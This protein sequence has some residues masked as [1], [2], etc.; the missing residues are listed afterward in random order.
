MNLRDLRY[1]VAVA[2]YRHF[3]RAAE[4]CHVSQPTLS[5]QLAKLED[6]LGVKLFERTNRAVTVTPVGS[7][8]AAAARLAVENAERV[9]EIARENKDPL[10]G[11]LRIGV[12]PTLA[13][14][15]MPWLLRPVRTRLPGLR[16]SL[17]EETTAHLTERLL[18]HEIDAAFLATPVA[19]EPALRAIELFDEPFWLAAPPDHPLAKTAHVTRKDIIEAGL[20]MLSD[21]HCLKQQTLEVCRHRSKE[22]ESSVPD[23]RASSLDTLLELVA[24]G[25]GC[26]L[27][28]AL[29]TRGPWARSR[30]M[31]LKRLPIDGAYRRVSLVLRTTF[32]RAAAV[33]ALAALVAEEVPRDLVR[34]V[35]RSARKAAA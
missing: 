4:A 25:L 22:P 8:V 6:Y 12:L 10:A 19:D 18:R 5:T 20:L 28:P 32:P 16:L 13:P 30:R 14:Y 35:T 27:I 24:A 9:L 33:E 1:L 34:I 3:G 2:D 7:R 21:E 26:T 29:A 31:V 15:L 23:L 11:P 17:T